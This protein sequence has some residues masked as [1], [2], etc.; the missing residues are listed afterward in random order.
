MSEMQDRNHEAGPFFSAFTESGVPQDDVPELWDTFL[1]QVPDG[2][3]L[4][5]FVRMHAG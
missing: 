4:N 1:F 2:A 3:D 5:H